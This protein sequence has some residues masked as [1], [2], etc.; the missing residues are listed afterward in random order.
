MYVYVDGSFVKAGAGWGWVAVDSAGK[1]VA[2]ASGALREAPSRNIDG[3]LSAALGG[4]MW[5]RYQGSMWWPRVVVCHDYTGIRE[6][7]AGSWAAKSAAATRYVEALEA[8]QIRGQ[9]GS[10]VFFRHVKGH[11]GDRWNDWADRLAGRA[12]DGG[13]VGGAE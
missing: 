1:T 2:E 12:A 6:W 13:F 11:S 7:A 10:A 3:E 5:W 8:A 9:I 4:L